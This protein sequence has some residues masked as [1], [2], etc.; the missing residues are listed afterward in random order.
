M[1]GKKTDG[2]RLTWAQIVKKYPH[3][4]VGLVDVETGINEADVK[5]AVVKCTSKD[6][7]YDEMCLAALHNEIYMCYTTRNEDLISVDNPFDFTLF[8]ASPIAIIV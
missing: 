6:T 7:S 8:P 4:N 5:S 1:E 3:M 2:K